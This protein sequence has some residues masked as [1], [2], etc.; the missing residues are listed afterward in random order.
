MVCDDNFKFDGS[1]LRTFRLLL[2][3]GGIYAFES[4]FVYQSPLK[5]SVIGSNVWGSLA[6][7]GDVLPFFKWNI[8]KRSTFPS[9]L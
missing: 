3:R 5:M 8:Y 2:T 9:K 6:P 7:Y 1:K 4:H